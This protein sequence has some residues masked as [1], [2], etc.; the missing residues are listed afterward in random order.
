MA[1]EIPI[2]Q[3]INVRAMEQRHITE[4]QDY[5]SIWIGKL[6]FWILYFILKVLMHN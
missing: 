2:Q 3:Q 6:I 4:Q 1:Y 5:N